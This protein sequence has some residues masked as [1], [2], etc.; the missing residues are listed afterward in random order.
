MKKTP[1]MKGGPKSGRISVCVCIAE[2]PRRL[3]L[4]PVRDGL[5]AR[6]ST[7]LRIDGRSYK[8]EIFHACSAR[9]RIHRFWRVLRAQG[10]VFPD[11]GTRQGRD[12][13][14]P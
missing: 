10:Y 4:R 9:R 2:V 8:G 1:E 5:G 12:R 6:S 14:V 3:D 7:L 11:V 13:Q